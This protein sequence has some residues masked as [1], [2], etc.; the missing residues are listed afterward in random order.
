MKKLSIEKFINKAKE[1]HGNKYDYSKTIYELSNKKVCIICPIHG[2]FWVKPNNHLNGCGCPK[3]AIEKRKKQFLMN[4]ND[5]IKKA[6]K[7][8]NNKYDYS[9]VEY[10]GSKKK[11]DIICPKHGDFWIRPNNH[12]IGQGCPMCA[13]ENRRESLVMTNE[14]F[15]EKAQKI[16]GNEY[17]YSKVNYVN[18][19]TPVTIICKKHGEFKQTPYHHLI[20][21]GCQKCNIE[22]LADLRRSNTNEFIEKAKKIHNDKFDYSKVK[23]INNSTPVT[24]IC[25][26]HGEFKQTPADH[27]SGY[28]CPKCNSSHLER[29]IRQLL[30]DNHIEFD[31]QKKF[32]WLGRQSLDFYIKNKNIAIECQGEQHYKPKEIFGGNEGFIKRKVLDERKRRLCEENNVTLLYYA[33]KKYNDEIIT[34]KD[35]LIF[36]IS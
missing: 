8:H 18:S 27:L 33:N 19:K 16:H 29:E 7:L 2:E 36:L 26:K 20:G 35:K 3:C 5:F 21:N 13:N 31:E 6:K 23:Y 28:G 10:K 24:I 34:D 9:K 30:T 25:K 11:V 17:D 12:L 22:K 32:D 4:K 14:E 15:I 1:V